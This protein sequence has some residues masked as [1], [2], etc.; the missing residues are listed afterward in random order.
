[1]MGF[2]QIEGRV[3][4]GVWGEGREGRKENLYVCG[5]GGGNRKL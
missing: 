5:D 1:M 4:K 3:G 2:V